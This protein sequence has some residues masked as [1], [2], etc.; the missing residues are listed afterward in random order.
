MAYLVMSLITFITYGVDKR[1]A[2]R[3]D[4]RV[5][6]ITLHALELFFGFPGALLAQQV[7]R[8]KRKK[9]RYLVVF[10]ILVLVHAAIAAWLLVDSR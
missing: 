1:R 7:F 5:P 6:E 2:I 8:H 9:P 3:G 10:W 4:R